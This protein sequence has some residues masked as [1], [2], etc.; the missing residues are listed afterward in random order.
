MSRLAL[1]SQYISHTFDHIS[2]AFLFLFHAHCAV[3][4]DLINLLD[5]FDRS[6]SCFW[7]CV[8]KNLIWALV[9][10]L[11]SSSETCFGTCRLAFLTISL[12]CPLTSF[13]S[14]LI[15][16]LS[17]YHCLWAPASGFVGRPF[18]TR[19]FFMNSAIYAFV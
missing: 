19:F 13:L 8:W 18:F 16:C 1:S 6:T 12:N 14:A 10:L 4:L 9:C 11:V 5:H 3:L 2:Y 7:V 15:Y 17:R